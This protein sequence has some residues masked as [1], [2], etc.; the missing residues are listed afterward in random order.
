MLICLY[1]F[2]DRSMRARPFDKIEVFLCFYILKMLTL[3]ITRR[4]LFHS[5]E[6]KIH[7][8]V[9]RTV[10]VSLPHHAYFYDEP[11]YFGHDFMDIRIE[12]TETE[13]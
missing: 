12:Y 3:Y 4:P 2:S 8:N 13:L 10:R 5:R 6:I 11:C 1:I 7:K 9:K